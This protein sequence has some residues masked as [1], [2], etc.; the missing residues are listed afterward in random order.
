[1]ILSYSNVQ[2]IIYFITKCRKSIVQK[3]NVLIKF[4]KPNFYYTV[5]NLRYY[6]SKF[7]ETNTKTVILFLLSS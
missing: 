2:T 1:M 7:M 4:E 6:N 3:T 5:Q